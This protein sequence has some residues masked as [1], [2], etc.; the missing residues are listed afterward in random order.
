MTFHEELLARLPDRIGDGLWQKR[1]CLRRPGGESE[2][3]FG[4]DAR[5]Q[6]RLFIMVFRTERRVRCILPRCL[7]TYTVAKRKRGYPT[8]PL[9]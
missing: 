6:G 7:A 5:S 3:R 2:A 4:A 1:K 9:T 8:T